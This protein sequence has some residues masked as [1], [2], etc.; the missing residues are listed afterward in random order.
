MY[1]KSFSIS[2]SAAGEDHAIYMQVFLSGKIFHQFNNNKK[3]KSN[4]RN[5]FVN[6]KAAL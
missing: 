1:Y 6:S 5:T 3:K 4:Q 2:K